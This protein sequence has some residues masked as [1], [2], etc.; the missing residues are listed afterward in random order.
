MNILLLIYLFT[1]SN[2]QASGDH[3]RFGPTKWD[4]IKPP[5]PKI[6]WEDKDKSPKIYPQTKEVSGECFLDDKWGECDCD[7]PF[8]L[9]WKTVR[10]VYCFA[11]E[12]RVCILSSNFI[13]PF[14]AP[15]IIY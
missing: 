14:S 3:V 12:L 6:P 7:I 4:L 15:D 10:G 5:N 8:E 1:I 9:L 2:H 13:P 11:C